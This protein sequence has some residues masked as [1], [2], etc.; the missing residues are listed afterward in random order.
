MARYAEGPRDQVDLVVGQWVE[1]CILDDRSL[2]FPDRAH[3]WTGANLAWVFAALKD[4]A[5]VGT[6]GGGKFDSKWKL[7]LESASPDQRVLAAD[8]MVVYFLFTNA[9]SGE[10]KRQLVDLSLGDAA[11]DSAPAA[12]VLA[13]LDQGIGD[14]GMHFNLG[15]DVHLRF[16]LDAARRL[17]DRPSDELQ[18]LLASPWELAAVIDDGGEPTHAMRHVLLH[19]LRPDEFERIANG[20]HKSAIVSAFDG[21]LEDVEAADNDE[22]LFALRKRVAEYVPGAP[23]MNHEAGPDFYYSPLKEMWRGGGLAGGEGASDI[24][25]LEWKKQIVLHGPPGTG[26]TREAEELGGALIRRAALKAWGPARYFASEDELTALV[27]RQSVGAGGLETAGG[28]P[29]SNV[30]WV[31]LHPAYG[32]SEFVRGLRLEGNTTRYEPGLLPQIVEHYHAQPEDQRFPVVLVLD[33]MNRT[34]L[35][36]MLGEAFSLLEGDKRD[37]VLVL[38]G[39]NKGE[40]AATLALPGDLYVIGTMN[41]IDQSVEALDFALRRRFLWKD[42]RFEADAL[43]DMIRGAWGKLVPSRF[44]FVNAEEQVRQLGDRAVALNEAI[45]SSP[46][47]GRPYEIG[48]SQFA[49]VTFFLGKSLASRKSVQLGTYLWTGKGKPQPALTDLWSWSLGPL[50]EQYLAGSDVRDAE[51]K[52]L[53]SVFLDGASPA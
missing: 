14:P 20:A 5:L 47:L 40:P 16:L 4:G 44:K 45:A 33:E 31:Q 41:E 19:L 6:A 43:Y 9:V 51:L 52:R 1:R 36:A 10:K 39:Q 35:S 21:M 27:S 12:D 38:P 8:V 37:K 48:H 22:R 23:G 30:F 32:Y 46:E 7:Q 25:A 42:C 26:K 17:K 34:D 15:R 53:R 50:L 24:E 18:G 2:L 49:E 11:G 29:P 13:A 28:V 3:V